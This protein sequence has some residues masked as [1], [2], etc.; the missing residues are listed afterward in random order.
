[1]NRGDD[2]SLEA[3]AVR[4]KGGDTASFDELVARLRGPLVAFLARRLP[5]VDDAD[6]VSRLVTTTLRPGQTVTFTVLRGKKRVS[7]PVTLGN[8]PSSG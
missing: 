1:M 3:L 5:R 7:I 8:R 6:D 2:M 4:A